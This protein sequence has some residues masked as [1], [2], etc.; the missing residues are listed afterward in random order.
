MTTMIRVDLVC[1]CCGHEFQARALGSTNT[2][3]PL[4]TDLHRHAGGLDP[5]PL[6]IHGCGKCGYSGFPER[7]E[8]QSP[9]R[10]GGAA[11]D[12]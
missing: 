7:N 4:T 3:G 6:M 2:C 9:I 11:G 10:T 1:P 12:S 8:G 5:L